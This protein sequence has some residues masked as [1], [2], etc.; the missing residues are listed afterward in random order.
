[1]PVLTTES[2]TGDPVLP[3]CYQPWRP[4]SHL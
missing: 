4:L 3:R 2:E 1:M